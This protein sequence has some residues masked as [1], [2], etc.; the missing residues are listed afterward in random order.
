MAL[1]KTFSVMYCSMEDSIGGRGNIILPILTLFQIDHIFPA[2]L[3]LESRCADDLQPQSAL[4]IRSAHHP[5]G[6]LRVRLRQFHRVAF[7]VRVKAD[8]ELALLTRLKSTRDDHVA[9]GGEAMTEEHAEWMARMMRK[10]MANKQPPARKEGERDNDELMVEMMNKK[11]IMMIMMIMMIEIAAWR[12]R[13][14]KC[15]GKWDRIVGLWRSEDQAENS[16]QPARIDVS[17]RDY[18]FGFLV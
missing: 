14:E 1:L 9:T 7:L 5:P 12:K 10:N 6:L 11:M 15:A 13:E 2:Y 17:G 4:I 8:Q 16:N 18:R 3:F